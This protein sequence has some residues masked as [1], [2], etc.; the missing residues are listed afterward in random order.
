MHDPTL[1]DAVVKSDNCTL[2]DY[3]GR[4]LRFRLHNGLLY[5]RLQF[6]LNFLF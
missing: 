5:D 6:T 2:H 3:F 4:L 1:N